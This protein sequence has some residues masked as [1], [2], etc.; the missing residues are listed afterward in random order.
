[1]RGRRRPRRGWYWWCLS[2]AIV[3]LHTPWR[4]MGLAAESFVLRPAQARISSGDERYWEAQSL[5]T[6]LARMGWTTSYTHGL[7]TRGERAYGLTDRAQ[8]S[9]AIEAGLRWNE[10]YSVLAHEGGHIL[11]P[12]WVSAVQ[13]EVFAEAVAA[14]VVRD[15]P[16][17][18]ARYLAAY[19]WDVLTVLLTEWRQVYHVAAILRG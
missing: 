19:R 7:M 5:E 1:M 8:H 9:I 2:A 14:L 13:G 10:R 18:H 4:L 3:A 6:R 16:R 12:D 17:E 11:Q 15:G